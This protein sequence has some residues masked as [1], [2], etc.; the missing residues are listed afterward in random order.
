MLSRR[1]VI[2][3]IFGHENETL[4][5]SAKSSSVRIL[6][7][8]FSLNQQSPPRHIP[9]SMCQNFQRVA[10]AIKGYPMYGPE[11]GPAGAHMR[12]RVGRVFRSHPH[13]PRFEFRQEV[14]ADTGPFVSLMSKQEAK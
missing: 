12:V 9:E 13:H 3:C 8:L 11:N 5:S 2:E 6:C 10:A 14:V 1:C 4:L 7:T